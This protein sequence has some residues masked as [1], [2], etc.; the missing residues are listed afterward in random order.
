M[1]DK[2]IVDRLYAFFEKEF[3]VEILEIQQQALQEQKHILAVKE[4]TDAC[5]QNLIDTEIGRLQ[6]ICNAYK[7]I[8][9]Y[10]KENKS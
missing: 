6:D 10:I 5:I 7:V 4:S 9:D 2:K 8:I 1:D 3:L